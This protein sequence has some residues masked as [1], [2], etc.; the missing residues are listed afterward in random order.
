MSITFRYHVAGVVATRD[1]RETLESEVSLF[2]NY[3]VGDS[4]MTPSRSEDRQAFERAG[5]ELGSKARA[6]ILQRIALFRP[7]GPDAGFRHKTKYRWLVKGDGL[8]VTDVSPGSSAG[9]A[10]LLPGDRIRRIDG[11]GG[12][13]EMDERVLRVILL[14]DRETVHNAFFDRSVKL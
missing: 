9:R 6:W 4:R 8:E 1:A 3:Q 7:T 14:P 12:T 11:E 2:Q 10:G 13:A 5:K